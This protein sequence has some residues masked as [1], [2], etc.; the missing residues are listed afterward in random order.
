MT[1]ETQPP[2]DPSPPETTKQKQNGWIRKVIV[3]CAVAALVVIAWIRF[4]DALSLQ[5]LAQKEGEFRQYQAD[6]PALVY[7]LAFTIYVASTSLSLPG[8]TAMTLIVGWFFGFWPALLLVSFASTTGAT[9]AFTFSRYL[10][11]DSIQNRFGSRLK[12]FNEALKKE[13]AFYLFTLRLI[14]LV[15]FFVI[16]LVM[17]LTPIK[18]ST[19]WWV[20]QLGML[21]GTAVFVYA[22]SSVPSLQTLADKG[23]GGILSPQLLAAFILLGLFPITIKKIMSRFHPAS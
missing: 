2:P 3:L 15:P 5:S 1:Q 8:A 9:L 20:S 13:G 6:H 14:P 16:N 10:L 12:S 22:G 11:H 21:P 7:G 19:F 17:G 4:E 18:T 23:A